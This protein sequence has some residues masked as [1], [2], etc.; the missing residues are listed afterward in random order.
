[1]SNVSALLQLLPPKTQA[2]L[3]RSANASKGLTSSNLLGRYQS[4][5]RSNGLQFSDL[6]EYSL[7]DEVRLIDWKSS[8]RSS[9]T[10][11][12]NFEEERQLKILAIINLSSSLKAS[13]TGEYLRSLGG[14]F[15]EEKKLALADTLIDKPITYAKAIEFTALLAA[16]ACITNDQFGLYSSQEVNNLLIPKSSTSHWQRVGA[17]FKNIIA[18]NTII[19]SNNS[20]DSQKLDELLKKLHKNQRNLKIF[21]ISDFIGDFSLLKASLK[22]FRNLGTLN[23][24]H[25]CPEI[26]FYIPLNRGLVRIKDPVSLNNFEV[27]SSNENSIK[28][29]EQQLI[30]FSKSIKDLAKECAANYLRITNQTEI[31]LFQKNRI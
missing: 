24:V 5:F 3:R 7:G 11:V 30:D 25:I 16:L 8:A 13:L 1:M 6:R 9:K 18:N 22:K 21:F 14:E 12:K 31:E 26:D 27:N 10:F 29:F 23:F 4:L 19:D 28:F 15:K 20:L 2:R 17:W